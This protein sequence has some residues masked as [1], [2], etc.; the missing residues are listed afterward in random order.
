M[1]LQFPERLQYVAEGKKTMRLLVGTFS[2]AA[3]KQRTLFSGASR[4]RSFTE[5]QISFRWYENGK[6]QG[7]FPV[8]TGTIDSRKVKQGS[9]SP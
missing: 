9:P 4:Q 1:Q 8:I 7:D 2:M 6:E 5:Y 3:E